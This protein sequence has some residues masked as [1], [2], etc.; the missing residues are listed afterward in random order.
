MCHLHPKATTFVATERKEGTLG[1]MRLSLCAVRWWV[2]VLMPLLSACQCQVDVPPRTYAC[3]DDS[4]C[5]PTFSCRDGICVSLDGGDVGGGQGGAGGGAGGVAGGQAGGD[6]GGMGG[7]SVAPNALVFVS[8]PPVRPLAG[9][10]FTATLEAQNAGLPAPVATS[11]AIA[12]AT[13]PNGGVRVYSDTNCT[14]SAAAVTLPAGS[15]QVTLSL[16]AVTGVTVSVLAS[17]PFGSAMQ[18]VDVAPAVNRGSCAFGDAGTSAVALSCPLA[19]V[20]DPSRTLVVFQATGASEPASSAIA[21]CALA[22]D[23]GAAQAASL[24]CV[25]GSAD[26]GLLV[27]WQ[28]LELP[29]GLSVLRLQGSCQS[30]PLT[31]D[32]PG[33][34][35]PQ[36]SFV[37]RSTSTIGSNLDDEELLVTRLISGTQV[38]YDF[39]VAATGCEGG[40]YEVQ[41]AQLSGL[42]VTR[43]SV[44]AGLGGAS[45]SVSGLPA[46]SL[47]SMV[48]VQ[49]KAATGNPTFCNFL[50][51]GAVTTPTS[52]V[53][54]R[55]AG[56]GS[57]TSATLAQ[58]HW[59]RLD[60]GTKARVQTLTAQM[61]SNALTQDVALS[62]VDPTRT[63]VIA[64]GQA[65]SGQGAGESAFSATGN[66]IGEG[67]A[68]FE[69]TSPTNVR[70]TR[71][72]A[73]A[74]ATFTFYAI[75]IDP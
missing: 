43:G 75:E 27:S 65:A 33:S 39:G 64:S 25:R 52:L 60:F 48:L 37:L 47:N 11:T 42:T 8:T 61:A 5:A 12:V 13:S 66:F 2:L 70:V 69:L 62:T 36:N 20:S 46:A 9:T 4:E 30:H 59:E 3:A 68:R 63:L 6:A 54:N 56:N 21:R 15:S 32:L 51:R 67:L 58:L 22:V 74:A 26:G 10:C 41:V 72:R 1:A 57:C 71:G 17:A 18:M 53:F 35:T 40:Q 34:V 24:E 55:G 29:Q 19:P 28:T 7:G 45:A 14:T 73:T 38:E 49:P 50:V 16:K 23:G 44:D 31:I